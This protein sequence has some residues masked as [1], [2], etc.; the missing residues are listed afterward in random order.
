[1][2][3]QLIAQA[4]T[5]KLPKEK[6]PL[7]CS[8]CLG[9][10]FSVATTVQQVQAPSAGIILGGP[11]MPL[12]A[13]TCSVCGHIDWFNLKVL[14]IV[15]DGTTGEASPQEIAERIDSELRKHMNGGQ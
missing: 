8:A 12:V 7:R 9:T 3:D 10:V 6:Q 5:A 11:I 2:L 1:M 15:Q 4:L 13:I 14:G